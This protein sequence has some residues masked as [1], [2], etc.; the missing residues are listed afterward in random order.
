MCRGLLALFVAVALSFT[1]SAVTFDQTDPPQSSKTSTKKGTQKPGSRKVGTGNGQQPAPDNAAQTTKMVDAIE[2][3]FLEPGMKQG[4]HLKGKFPAG[5]TV[6]G[7]GVEVIDVGAQDIFLNVTTPATEGPIYFK[8][9]PQGGHSESVSMDVVTVGG[10][11]QVDVDVTQQSSAS[12]VEPNK[13]DVAAVSASCDLPTNYSYAAFNAST[14]KFTEMGTK[15]FCDAFSKVKVTPPPTKAALKEAKTA[16]KTNKQ[17]LPNPNSTYRKEGDRVQFVVCNKNP[18]LAS[19]DFS[20]T[21][22]PI[23]NDDLSTFLGILVPGLGAGKAAGNAQGSANKLAANDLEELFSA[24]VTKGF[25]KPVPHAAAPTSSKFVPIADPVQV[26]LNKITSKLN[27]ADGEYSN[28]RACFFS[29]RTNLLQSDKI[30]DQRLADTVALS[31][32]LSILNTNTSAVTGAVNSTISTMQG[33]VSK[34]IQS[35]QNGPYAGDALTLQQIATLQADA[36]ILTSQGCISHAASTIVGQVLAGTSGIDSILGDSGSFVEETDIQMFDPTTVNW[37]IKSSAPATNTAKVLASFAALSSD[38][39]DS[40]LNKTT[41][42]GGTG[43]QGQKGGGNDGGTPPNSK[44]SD[45]SS[46]GAARNV[47][48]APRGAILSDMRNESEMEQ[49][50]YQLRYASFKVSPAQPDVDPQ[51][52]SNNNGGGDQTGNSKKQGGNGSTDSQQNATPTPGATYSGTY[53]FGAPRVVVSAGVAAVVGLQNRQYQKVQAK[54]Q[55]SGTTIEYSTNSSFRLSPLI[56]AHGRLYQYHEDNS[57]W[58]TLGVSASSN[59]S[60][61]SAEYL[62]GLTASFFHNW[63]FLTPGLYIGQVQSLTGG[64]KVGDQLP[65]SFTGSIPVQQSY[66]PGFGLALSFRVPGTSA[67]KNKT[68]NQNG[69]PSNS[70]GTATNS[71]KGSK[72]SSSQ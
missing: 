29:K 16:A 60:G 11:C 15:D 35:A 19:S 28:F 8:V 42:P 20:M 18:F 43:N 47:P 27:T 53:T 30:C 3:L 52:G 10:N 64:Y 63:V 68:Q 46:P 48:I 38:P 31:K 66:K 36:T 12:C 25:E 59:N 5:S 51:S 40:C 2:P 58:A 56:M 23:A 37:S 34:R 71:G 62:I 50:L 44:G 67:P 32:N 4:V 33:V 70:N 14:K 41:P 26:C 69:T 6:T 72:G 17:L 49:M 61:V 45:N 24:Q 65:S 9:G 21:T 54:G 7:D 22:T 13:D 1:V 39:Y 55:T 57:I